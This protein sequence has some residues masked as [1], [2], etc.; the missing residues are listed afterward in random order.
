[1]N[2]YIFHFRKNKK[3]I[4]LFSFV[5]RNLIKSYYIIHE[6]LNLNSLPPKKDIPVPFLLRKYWNV[7]WKEKDKI[8]K[9][10]L[11]PSN[12]KIVDIQ[13]IWEFTQIIASIN[14]L[15]QFLH[16]NSQIP[17]S[18]SFFALNFGYI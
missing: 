1:M 10:F 7:L 14:S 4:L 9:E 15:P 8:G 16:L 18:K 3:V 5:R 12:I 11:N 17:S 6:N 2:K 13:R